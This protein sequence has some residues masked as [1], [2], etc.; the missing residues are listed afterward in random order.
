M[1]KTRLPLLVLATLSSKFA[2]AHDAGP[3]DP[4][5]VVVV[6]T[7]ADIASCDAAVRKPIDAATGLKLDDCS[8]VPLTGL[9]HVPDLST[10]AVKQFYVG[11]SPAKWIDGVPNR[12]T[13]GNSITNYGPGTTGALEVHGAHADNANIAYTKCMHLA[14]GDYKNGHFAEGYY[15][16]EATYGIQ[17]ILAATS[18]RDTAGAAPQKMCIASDLEFHPDHGHFHMNAVG[19]Y[20]LLPVMPGDKPQILPANIGARTASHKSQKIS[21]CLIDVNKL[22]PQAGQNY[23]DAC[24]TGVQ[25]ISAGFADFYSRWLDD[26][27]IDGVADGSYWFAT[28]ANPAGF[29]LEAN[30]ENNTSYTYITVK[31]TK[32][33][34]S[35]TYTSMPTRHISGNKKVQNP[36]NQVR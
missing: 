20:E 12:L 18:P 36:A 2:F 7:Y 32:V 14:A 25:G 22:D 6:G 15:T 21:F 11:W 13:F 35:A 3:L 19:L 4:T 29:F 30:L 26:Q 23:Y 10:Q 27:W 16:V 24:D 9:G 5:Q 34:V 8:A 33:T 28:T 17:H 31:G 1:R